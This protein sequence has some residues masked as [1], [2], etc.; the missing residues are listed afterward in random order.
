MIR[1]FQISNS[2]TI[3]IFHY[4]YGLITKLV[5]KMKNASLQFQAQTFTRAVII[6]HI[7]YARHL[8]VHDDVHSHQYSRSRLSIDIFGSNLIN[9]FQLSL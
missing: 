8:S 5:Y 9:F 7:F 6:M 2:K 3:T 4:S 1:F